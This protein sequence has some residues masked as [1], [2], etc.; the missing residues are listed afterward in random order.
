MG[1][2]TWQ[3]AC[4]LGALAMLMMGETRKEK[5]QRET[6]DYW[7][8]KMIERSKQSPVKLIYE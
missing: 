8:K 6:D 2:V 7:R 5:A 4:V 3:A 1:K